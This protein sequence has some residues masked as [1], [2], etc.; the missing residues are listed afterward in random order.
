[1]SIFGF[2][3]K[4]DATAESGRERRSQIQE[5][6]ET[7]RRNSRRD[8]EEFPEDEASFKAF[9]SILEQA[10][11]KHINSQRP[12]KTEKNPDLTQQRPVNADLLVYIPQDRMSA[13]ACVLPALNGGEELNR[14]K[15]DEDLHYEGVCWGL[16]ER[17]ISRLLVNQDYLLRICP[18]A[19]GNLPKDG[20]D[21]E[22]TELFEH[23]EELQLE[24]G[25]GEELDFSQKRLLQPIRKGEIICQI[26]QPTPA[27]DGRDV[28]G[29]IF[30]GR[31][32]VQA[33]IP[34]GTN[35]RVSSDGQLL[36]A[37]LDGIVT[38]VGINFVVRRQSIIIGD[39]NREVG[40]LTCLGDIFIS[41]DVVD[42]MTVE[43]AGNVVIQ[44][45]VYD[46]HIISGGTI[47]V[48]KG[49][50]GE[51]KATLRAAHQ[52]QCAVIEN[53][54]ATAGKSIYSEVLMDSKVISKDGSIYVTSGRGLLLGGD[55]RARNSIFARKVGNLSGVLNKLTV[56][57]CPGLNER[58][59][60]AETDLAESRATLE[61]LRKSISALRMGGDTLSL[62]KRALLAQLVEQRTLYEKQEES[63][64]QSLKALKKTLQAACTGK[65][66]CEELNPVTQVQIGDKSA[67]LQTA[68]KNCSV[69]IYAGKVMVK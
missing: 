27:V 29:H 64:V 5:W 56:G 43:A 25:E 50:K 47:R 41:G 32:G 11:P 10:V 46:G 4:L 20:E 57:Y 13:F 66:T 51:H 45:G 18:I 35:T 62:E 60:E 59:E 23:R 63:Q 33:R 31:D 38:T 8:L 48:Q 22:I 55:V 68:E 19:R 42:G 3:T 26:K 67:T 40:N 21:G 36:L 28:T 14:E 65:I 1:M 24:I 69:Y 58:L 53:A 52:L 49:V 54:T 15:L 30:H 7:I 37:D 34:A 9:Q 12:P 39:V 17:M 44:G 2:F 6:L 16:D 61:K